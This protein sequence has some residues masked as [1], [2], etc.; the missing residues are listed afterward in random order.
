[1]FGVKIKIKMTYLYWRELNVYW[2]CGG[3]TH[4]YTSSTLQIPTIFFIPKVPGSEN[5]SQRNYSALD[6]IVYTLY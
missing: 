5:N 3:G 4:T 1:M 6:V 2:K